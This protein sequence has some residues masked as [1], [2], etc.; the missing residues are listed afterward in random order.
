MVS[1]DSQAEKLKYT[2]L[3]DY[4]DFYLCPLAIKMGM[5][6]TEF[7]EGDPDYFWNYCDAYEEKE[8]ELYDK[9]NYN[10]YIDGIY[11]MFAVGQNFTKKEIY[12]KE[13]L[14]MK[15]NTPSKTVEE[16]NDRWKAYFMAN[17]RISN[18]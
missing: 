1:N 10:A 7:W 2:N 3:L 11:H 14:S 15:L 12:P 9:M 4:F 8:K 13:P 6:A 5:T 18:V 17:L 16:N